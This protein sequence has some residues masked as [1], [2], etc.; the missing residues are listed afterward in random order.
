MQADGPGKGLSAAPGIRGQRRPR[1]PGQHSPDPEPHFSIPSIVF[2][3]QDFFKEFARKLWG[4]T[5][6]FSLAVSDKPQQHRG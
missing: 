3:Q 5:A 4:Q 2:H 1:E 6:H